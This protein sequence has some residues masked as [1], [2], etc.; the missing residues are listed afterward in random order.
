MKK[1]DTITSGISAGINRLDDRLRRVCGNM[2]P[3][4]HFM[5]VLILCIVFGVTN[6]YITVSAI[7]NMGK[8][9]AAKELQEIERQK[10]IPVEIPDNPSNKPL[11]EKINESANR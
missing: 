2:S 3:F 4:K 6:L 8:E 7:Y 11:K 5:I 9:N 10:I 1:V